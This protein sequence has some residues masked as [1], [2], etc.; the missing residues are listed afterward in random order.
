ML[1]SAGWYH[2]KSPAPE[3]KELYEQGLVKAELWGFVEDEYI[4]SLGR[5]KSKT[6]TFDQ[7]VASYYKTHKSEPNCRNLAAAFGIFNTHHRFIITK[8]LENLDTRDNWMATPI[9]Q[10]MQKDHLEE[11]EE[12]KDQLTEQRAQYAKELQK[13]QEKEDSEMNEEEPVAPTKLT[14]PASK[15]GRRVKEMAEPQPSSSKAKASKG[16]LKAPPARRI[17][18]EMIDSFASSSSNIKSSLEDTKTPSTSGRHARD[19]V[20][21]L[22][23][24]SSI[25][26]KTTVGK[27]SLPRR[28]LKRS[29]EETEPSPKNKTLATNASSGPPKTSRSSKFMGPP[30]QTSSMDSSGAS[31]RRENSRLGEHTGNVATTSKNARVVPS[32]SSRPT[33]SGKGRKSRIEDDDRFASLRRVRDGGRNR[34]EF[35]PFSPRDNSGGLKIEAVPKSGLAKDWPQLRPGRGRPPIEYVKLPDTTTRPGGVWTCPEDGCNRRVLDADYIP[36]KLEIERHWAM[37]GQKMQEMLN[38]VG[39]EQQQ[40]GS[41]AQ[42]RYVF[43]FVYTYLYSMANDV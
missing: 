1:G 40:M 9:G 6:A 8:L 4:S 25:K 31:L 28:N 24:H 20:I 2:L 10:Q 22:E 18:Q 42:V 12:I 13:R 29:I 33:L 17:N 15:R 37:H 34:N 35:P 23:S 30:K 19:E 14:T 27:A 32:T 16:I 21:D 38:I 11:I 3:Y 5:K 39:Y 7:L 41:A 43:G 26:P 36:G